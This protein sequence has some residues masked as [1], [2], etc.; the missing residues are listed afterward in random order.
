MLACTLFT[1]LMLPVH[2]PFHESDDFFLRFSAETAAAIVGWMKFTRISCF[3]LSYLLR[4]PYFS[5]RPVRVLECF[6][7]LALR[8]PFLLSR[9]SLVIVFIR[10]IPSSTNSPIAYRQVLFQR[11]A[12][13]FLL[14][15]SA[16]SVTSPHPGPHLY[17]Y[18]LS[19]RNFLPL[20]RGQG[21]S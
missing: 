3:G 16:S 6:V 2:Y 9:S 18:P 4:T 17:F 7:W 21:F 15:S 19:F 5:L 13:T 11:S 20:P 14:S 1:T 12:T 8:T 10:S